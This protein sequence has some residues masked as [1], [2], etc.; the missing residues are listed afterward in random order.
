LAGIEF[1]YGLALNLRSKE[2][3]CDYAQK[4]FSHELKIE[5]CYLYL[6]EHPQKFSFRQK[7]IAIGVIAGVLVGVFTKNIGIWLPVG[8]A[9][10]A[11]IGYTRNENTKQ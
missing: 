9:I 10:G 5:N 3:N 4:F 2:T 7:S 1:K 6:M 8:I 11:G